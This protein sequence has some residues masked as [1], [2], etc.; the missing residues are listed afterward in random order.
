VIERDHRHVELD[1]NAHLGYLSSTVPN[2]EAQL[3]FTKGNSY[4][5]PKVALSSPA[6]PRL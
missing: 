4:A 5:N 1:G 6:E 2:G 3:A